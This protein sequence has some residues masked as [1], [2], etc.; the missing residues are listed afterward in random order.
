MCM[1]FRVRY[2]RHQHGWHVLHGCAWI[3]IH[4]HRSLPVESLLPE[5]QEWSHYIRDNHGPGSPRVAH[6]QYALQ[7]Q[8]F[9]SLGHL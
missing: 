1:G 9:E 6:L 3:F 7:N 8:E 5:E 2:R 4:V